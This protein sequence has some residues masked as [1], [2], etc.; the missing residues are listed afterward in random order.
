MKWYETTF[1]YASYTVYTLYILV[2]F[3]IWDKAPQYLRTIEKIR[4]ILVSL[5]LLYFFN[6]WRKKPNFNEFHRKIVFT[7]G[8]FLFISTIIGGI[9]HY[10]LP[11]EQ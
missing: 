3:G 8:I 2:L 10:K 4:A 5:L 1:I 6:P 7:S 9:L 11:S